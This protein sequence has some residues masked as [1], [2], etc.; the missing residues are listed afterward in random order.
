MA[1]PLYMCASCRKEFNFNNIKY[2]E[3]HNLIC[4]DCFKKK[5]IIRSVM[6]EPKSREPSKDQFICLDCRFKFK[7]TRGS[8]QKIKCPFCGKTKCMLVR[9]YKDENDLINDSMN[10]RFDY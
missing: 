9:K 2:D 1:T 6:E 3:S 10:H 8:E 4:N 7:I 5:P